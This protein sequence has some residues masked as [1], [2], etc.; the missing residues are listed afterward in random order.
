MIYILLESRVKVNL[1]AQ[2]EF[3]SMVNQE[4]VEPYICDLEV[5][6]E[7]KQLLT[8]LVI[9]HQLSDEPFRTQYHIV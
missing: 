4:G 3:Q 1:N 2:G 6:L 9:T 5:N 8:L 7:V